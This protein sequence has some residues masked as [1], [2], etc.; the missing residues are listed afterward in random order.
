MRY[1]LLTSPESF[2]DEIDLI[3]KIFDVGLDA[4]YIWKPNLSDRALERFLLAL[5]EPIRER[6]FL[7][8]SPSKALEFGLLGFHVSADFCVRNVDVA[9]RASGLLSV[10]AKNQD[11]WRNVPEVV[12]NK[13]STLVVDSLDGFPASAFVASD[14][15]ELP[16]GAENFFITSGI[17]E[18]ADPVSAWRRLCGR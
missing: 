18:F 17:W 10:H 9:M 5:A 2:V 7:C 3:E 16:A 1:A 14:A 11:D 4:L 13:V 8:G 6:S 12:R 15:T